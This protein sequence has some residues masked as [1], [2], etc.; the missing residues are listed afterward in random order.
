MGRYW[1][2]D[3]HG[4]SG[5]T[6]LVETDGRL[7]IIDVVRF[8]PSVTEL[9]DQQRIWD[10]IIGRVAPTLKPLVEAVSVE[11]EGVTP[12]PDLKRGVGGATGRKRANRADGGH[13]GHPGVGRSGG[14]P[15]HKRSRGDR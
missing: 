15:K 9:E 3:Q 10:E 14:S 8:G 1:L 6:A 12:H 11:E 2:L 7:Q 13:W 4:D 5:P